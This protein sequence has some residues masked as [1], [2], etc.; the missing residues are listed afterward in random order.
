MSHMDEVNADIEGANICP[1]KLCCNILL[2]KPD[3]STTCILCKS[4]MNR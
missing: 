2:Q 4:T 3:K 1:C